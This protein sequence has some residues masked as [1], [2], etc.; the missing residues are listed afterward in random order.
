MD[1]EW[2]LRRIQLEPVNVC[3]YNCPLCETHKKDW[4]PRRAVTLEEAKSIVQPAAN[5]LEGVVLYGTRGE[6]FMNKQLEEIT[7]Y[8][9]TNTRARVSIS[10]N[11]SLAG[12]ARAAGLL[13]AGL[14]Q[15]IFAIDGI[16]QETYEKY[17][18]GGTLDRVIRN[19]EQFCS[20]KHQGGYGTRVVFQFIPMAGNEHE[21]PDLPAFGY[22]LGADIVRLKFSTSVSRSRDFR[23]E[24]T[25]YP[26]STESNGEFRCPMGLDV[27]YVDPNGYAYPCCYAEG[28]KDLVIGNAVKED[29]NRIWNSPV[30][31]EIKRSFSEQSGFIDFCVTTCQNVTRQRKKILPRPGN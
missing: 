22:G 26:K 5:N 16:T 13:D 27:L 9:K 19:L 7:G 17:R 30:M 18:Q 25:S 10:T 29:V 20:L 12:R 15:I 14:D 4:V 11:G 6:P 2:P 24:N 23:V 28:N 21:V 8:L 3:N 1:T 31:R